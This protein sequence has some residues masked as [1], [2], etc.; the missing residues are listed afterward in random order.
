MP[1]ASQS[2]IVRKYPSPHGSRR[3]GHNR[4]L[5][6][7]SCCLVP[8]PQPASEHITPCFTRCS[9]STQPV[10]PP[11][12]RRDTPEVSDWLDRHCLA[13]Y[14][15]CI[16]DYPKPC[17]PERLATVNPQQPGRQQPYTPLTPSIS[18]LCQGRCC[19][20]PSPMP[21]RAT[22]RTRPPKADIPAVPLSARRSR[23][24]I[25]RKS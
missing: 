1:V 10:P 2:S 3:T 24:R 25:N 11:P 20:R 5:S 8:A 12:G 7:A 21:L 6:W 14:V 15:A 4:V 23:R 18:R 22:D 17:S 13:S 16:V 19:P 9:P